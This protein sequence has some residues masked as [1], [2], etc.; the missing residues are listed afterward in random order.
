[1]CSDSQP[2]GELRVK[3]VACTVP[4]PKKIYTT[5]STQYPNP[6]MT[7]NLQKGCFNPDITKVID[8]ISICG[9]V[10]IQICTN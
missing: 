1:M 8:C 10:T 3:N 6:F 9:L 7:L 4:K 2:K 5:E